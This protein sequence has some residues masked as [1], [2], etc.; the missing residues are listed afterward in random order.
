MLTPSN[1]HVALDDV[2]WLVTASP[3]YTLATIGTV[4]VPTS[5]QFVPSAD[6]YAVNVLPA[7]VSLTQCGA[8]DAEP[9][10]L[11]LV[12]PDRLRR[13]NATPF[14]A[15]TSMNACGESASSVS[16]TMTPAFTHALTF[17]TLATRAMIVPSPLRFV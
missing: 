5:V 4:S 13:W 3:T 6:S 12:W 1:V 17:G 11:T 9:A 10:V 15:E 16:R 2:V 8:V 14:D 7:R